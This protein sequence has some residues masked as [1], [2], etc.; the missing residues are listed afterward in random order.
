MRDRSA[1]RGEPEPQEYR[2]HLAR[3]A[4]WHV[5]RARS[6][7]LFP[8]QHGPV[9]GVSAYKEW[10]RTVAFCRWTSAGTTSQRFES[11]ISPS[12]VLAIPPLCAWMERDIHRRGLALA[13][14]L[15]GGGARSLL[16]GNLRFA[17]GE[18]SADVVGDRVGKRR[19][20][21]DRPATEIERVDVVREG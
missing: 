20:G 13:P 1:E 6:I 14:H 5:D 11:G 17:R 16:P 9:S 19:V 18:R 10:G 7:V 3:V 4:S 8:C 2:E 15:Q 21:V 12:A